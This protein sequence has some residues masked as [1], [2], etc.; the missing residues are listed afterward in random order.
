[1]AR[2]ARFG[3]WASGALP[4][5]IPSVKKF[6]RKT[7]EKKKYISY[8]RLSRLLKIWM[9]KQRN[10]KRKAIAAKLAKVAHISKKKAYKE[11]PLFEIIFKNSDEKE[12]ET[13]SRQLRL[14]EDELSYITNL[15]KL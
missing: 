15:R 10:L 1:M 5:S 3:G 13:F 7:G 4:T 12:I 6:R 2:R 11:L 8:K 9:A 14:D